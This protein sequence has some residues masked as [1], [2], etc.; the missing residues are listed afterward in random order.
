MYTNVNS[1]HSMLCATFQLITSQNIRKT[2][3]CISLF[4]AVN[5]DSNEPKDNILRQK[6]YVPR[7]SSERPRW[8]QGRCLVTFPGCSEM[9]MM[10]SSLKG[11]GTL[12]GGPSQNIQDVLGT[13]RG[14]LLQDVPYWSLHYIQRLQ[15]KP[16]IF[17]LLFFL[18]LFRYFH[19]IY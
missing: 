2:V 15:D 7:T 13:L 14:P 17:L 18:F 6:F 5:L 11:W 4:R 12:F 19:H 1:I 10:S 3:H 16:R 9:V 8:C